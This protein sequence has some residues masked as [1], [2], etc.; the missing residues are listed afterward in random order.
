MS[1]DNQNK[2]MQDISELPAFDVWSHSV[3][4]DLASALMA[5]L[6]IDKAESRT[7]EETCRTR[8][9]QAIN[10]AMKKFRDLR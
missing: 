5:I 6:S 9:T 10:D 2:T 4:N 3:M 7:Q 1:T 8:A